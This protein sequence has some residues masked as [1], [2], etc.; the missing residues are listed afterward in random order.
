[1]QP[2]RFSAVTNNSIGLKPRQGHYLD[3]SSIIGRIQRKEEELIDI[4]LKIDILAIS[5]ETKTLENT[6]Y[7]IRPEIYHTKNGNGNS[8]TFNVN[9]RFLIQGVETITLTL[10]HS[11]S[12]PTL[13]DWHITG[14]MELGRFYTG[15]D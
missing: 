2:F 5:S 11:T 13:T 8:Y 7:I 3:I 12:N 14:F 1:M 10:L 9:R 4:V 15:S 6:F